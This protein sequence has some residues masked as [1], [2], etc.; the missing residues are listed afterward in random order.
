LIDRVGGLD[1]G[2]LFDPLPPKPK[3]MHDRTYQRL[4]WHY[5]HF[6][7]KSFGSI[8]RRLGISLEDG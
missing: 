7:A 3:G 8:S 1:F 4:E 6:Q 5:A 2:T